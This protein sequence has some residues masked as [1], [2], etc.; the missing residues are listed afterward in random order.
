[1]DDKPMN[2]GG[3]APMLADVKQLRERARQEVS[4]GA[5]TPAYGANP[6]AVCGLLNQALATELV[7]S[8]R[9]KR[10]YFMATGL[11]SEAVKQEFLEHAQQ[12]EEHADRLAE[13]IVQLGGEPDFD[14]ATLVDRAHAEYVEGSGLREMIYEDLVAERVAIQSYTEMLKYLDGKD[15]VSHA[16]LREILAVEEEHAEDMVSLLQGLPATDSH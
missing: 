14:P 8:L 3:A 10:H 1:M 11:A 7:C 13:R 9:Y 6:E 5:V 15:P 16:L 12:E 4:S 2:P